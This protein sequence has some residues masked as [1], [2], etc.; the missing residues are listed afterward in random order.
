[1]DQTGA[2]QKAYQMGLFSEESLTL[3]YQG[4]SWPIVGDAGEKNSNSDAFHLKAKLKKSS[5]DS[6]I[7]GIPVTGIL[8]RRILLSANWG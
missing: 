4:T 3:S 1:M 7:H 6:F 5:S 2:E 8:S